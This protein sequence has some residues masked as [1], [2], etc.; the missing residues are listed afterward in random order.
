MKKPAIYF[1]HDDVT[2]DVFVCFGIEFLFNLSLFICP[3]KFL[4][5]DVE[6]LTKLG[7]K[8]EKVDII[9]LVEGTKRTN[10]LI[11]G[12]KDPRSTDASA[13]AMSMP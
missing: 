12:V 11:I 9:S 10:D 7:H 1:V 5:A 13:L 2:L 4:Q 8:V 6:S 3:A